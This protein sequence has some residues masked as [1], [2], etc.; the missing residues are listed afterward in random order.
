MQPKDGHLEVPSGPGL[1]VGFDEDQLKAHVLDP[2]E[3]VG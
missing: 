2:Y 3:P 1:G